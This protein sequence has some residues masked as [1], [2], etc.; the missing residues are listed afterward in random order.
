MLGIS[1]TCIGHRKRCKTIT[2]VRSLVNCGLPFETAWGSNSI[3]VN[4]FGSRRE[5]AVLASSFVHFLNDIV[6]AWMWL[7]EDAPWSLLHVC[8][9]VFMGVRRLGWNQRQWTWD[10]KWRLA[11]TSGSRKPTM[12]NLINESDG[13][14]IHPQ[15][16]QLKRRVEHFGEKFSPLR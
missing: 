5:F 3:S 15:K 11:K 8:V 9:R 7:K 10:L 4:H 13:S 14:L 12:S 6:D 2:P 1:K 16:H